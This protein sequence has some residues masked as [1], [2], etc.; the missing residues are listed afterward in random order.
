M[1]FAGLGGVSAAYGSVVTDALINSFAGGHADGY[2]IAQN[3]TMAFGVGAAS[4]ILSGEAVLYG[5]GIESP[6]LS[7]N[8]AVFGVVGTIGTLASPS[9]AHGSTFDTVSYGYDYGYNYGYK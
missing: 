8:T 2:E 4:T 5:L 1:G 3:A 6:T 9:S 7:F